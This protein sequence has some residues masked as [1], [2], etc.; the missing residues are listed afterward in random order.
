MLF[1]L[2]PRLSCAVKLVTGVKLG[3]HGSGLLVYLIKQPGCCVLGICFTLWRLG[4]F[5]IFV[6]LVNARN[7]FAYCSAVIAP[8]FRNS[9]CCLIALLRLSALLRYCWLT[10]SASCCVLILCCSASLAFACPLVTSPEDWQLIR[11]NLC[12][13]I[14]GRLV[15]LALKLFQNPPSF[16]L[17]GFSNIFV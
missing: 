10:R 9:L 6:H 4:W 11:A 12:F 17:L 16:A 2:N 8:A 3:L 7:I 5:R 1:E 15:N 14:S 13:I